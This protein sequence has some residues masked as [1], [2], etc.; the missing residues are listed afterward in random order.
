LI[1]GLFQFSHGS[2]VVPEHCTACGAGP[3]L[4]MGFFRQD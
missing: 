3:S 1:I 2:S 4:D